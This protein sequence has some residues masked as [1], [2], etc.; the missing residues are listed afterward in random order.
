MLKDWERHFAA[1]CYPTASVLKTLCCD[2]LNSYVLPPD[3]AC[4]YN[5]R[6]FGCKANED[7]KGLT[8]KRHEDGKLKQ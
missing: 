2:P 4:S 6:W 1:C 7:L 8:N 3:N 5:V